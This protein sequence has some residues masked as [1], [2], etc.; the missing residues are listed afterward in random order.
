MFTTI[1]GEKSRSNPQELK[2]NGLCEQRLHPVTQLSRPNGMSVTSGG[3]WPQ[4][5]HMTSTRTMNGQGKGNEGRRWSWRRGWPQSLKWR[6]FGGINRICCYGKKDIMS[7]MPSCPTFWGM[8]WSWSDWWR[9]KYFAMKSAY[10]AVQKSSDT[11]LRDEK[12]ANFVAFLKWNFKFFLL[13]RGG[14]P[15][16][17]TSPPGGF[18]T[19]PTPHGCLWWPFTPRAKVTGHCM[20]LTFAALYIMQWEL[21]QN[22]VTMK[23]HCWHCKTLLATC[24]CHLK[25]NRQHDAAEERAVHQHQG[26][27][28]QTAWAQ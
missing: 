17:H 3:G 16:L 8:P 23:R 10:S 6:R 1:S 22:T 14:H 4:S 18:A 20:L 7:A 5:I 11:R 19:N 15:P 21:K 13:W 2:S 24:N 27:H 26:C 12:R 9:A 25:E 28:H